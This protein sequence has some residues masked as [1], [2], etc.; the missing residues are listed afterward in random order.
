MRKRRFYAGESFVIDQEHDERVWATLD[1]GCNAACHSASWAARAER[2]LDMFDFRSEYREGS[3][4]KVFTGLGGNTVAAVGR[5]KF[6]FALAFTA[7]RGDIHRLSGTIESWELLGDGPFLFPID[8]QGKLGL[9]KD[10]ARSRIFIENKPG[11]YFRMYKDAKTGLMLI[12][13]ADFDLLNDEA[14]TPQ[15]LRAS[16]PMYDL[17]ATIP[18]PTCITG[19]TNASGKHVDILR[20]LTRLPGNHTLRFTHVAIGLDVMDEYPGTDGL[21]SPLHQ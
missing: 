12:N 11:F 15:L 13:V 1:E 7:E 16:K 2:Y 6:P 3:R 20:S 8:A 9:I 19:G 10:M 21:F 5:R 17:A 4:N 18:L 14:L